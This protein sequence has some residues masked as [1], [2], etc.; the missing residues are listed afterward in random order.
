MASRLPTLLRLGGSR[1]A[2]RGANL[3]RTIAA[4]QSCQ[5]QQRLFFSAGDEPPEQAS[6]SEEELKAKVAV[7][8]EEVKEVGEKMALIKQ[9]AQQAKRRHR[10]DLENESK[11]GITKLARDVLKVDS[12]LDRAVASI[13]AEELEEDAKLKA[14]HGRVQTLQ[15]NLSKVLGEFGVVKVNPMDEVFDPSKHE[16]MFS[17]AMPGKD[18]NIVFHVM[19]PGYMIHDRTLRAA[20]VGVTAAAS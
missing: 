10:S 2:H 18:A 20:K 7:L 3:H 11:F 17:M 8:K 14:L 6:P 9:D 1:L 5:W 12:N 4:P 13:K 15:G 16:A 19:E